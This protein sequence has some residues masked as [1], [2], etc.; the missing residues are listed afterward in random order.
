MSARSLNRHFFFL[1]AL[2]QLMVCITVA[3]ISPILVSLGYSNLR[4]GQVMTLGALASTLARPLWGYLN[5][6]FSCARQVT[7][8]GPAA[9]AACYF[10]LTWGGGRVWLTALAVMGLYV[11][12]VCMMNFVDSWALRLINSGMPLNY[13]GTRAGG[14]LSYAIGA[15][16]FGAMV[17]RWGFRP[18]NAVLWVLWALMC[19]VVLRIPNPPRAERQ[20]R[21]I[22]LARGIG[23]LRKNR[24]YCT[25]LAALFLCTLASGSME[26]FYSVLIL[27]AGGTEQD[28]GVALFIQAISELPVM[29]GYTRIRAKLRIPAA[30]LICVSMLCYAAKALVLGSAS[31]LGVILAAALFQSLSFALFTPACVDFMLET[32]PGEYLATGHL[33][34]LAVGQGAGA[35][36][37]NALSGVLSEAFGMGWMFRTVGVLALLAGA[38]ALWAAK[39]LNRGR[40]SRDI[41]GM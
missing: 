38:L 33:L 27:S 22:T 18:G 5:D 35:V 16:V 4:I 40:N 9:G 14:S 32:V 2:L 25:M 34:F 17:A 29:F 23:T 26:S 1:Q 11:T 31:S 10:L 39:M 15:V 30:K 28:V 3:Y 7:L 20:A 12:V 19:A 24:V 36:A 13:G 41:S 21:T 8:G 6:R 37:G